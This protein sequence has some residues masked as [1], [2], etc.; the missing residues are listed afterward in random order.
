MQQWHDHGYLHGDVKPENIVV[1]Q[2]RPTS[3]SERGSVG[4]ASGGETSKPCSG[5]SAHPLL[6]Y[7][8][9]V[10][11]A[12]TA[13]VCASAT[14]SDNRAASLPS[15]AP[16]ESAACD[17]SGDSTS[18]CSSDSAASSG[19]LDGSRYGH[20]ALASDSLSKAGPCSA[21]IHDSWAVQQPARY[22]TSR[23]QP[24][25]RRGEASMALDWFALGLTIHWMV[26]PWW[27]LNARVLTRSQAVG[28]YGRR[29]R[30]TS[31]VSSLG[32]Q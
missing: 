11:G 6:A 18:D 17:A 5:E 26:S 8:I 28:L 12:L 2:A 19:D 23:Y 1:A 13:T 20:A 4:S 9:D 21:V 25:D 14:D 24:S 7:F 16:V 31:S 3:S 22:Y 32:C 29:G 10:G 27:Y 15:A 30:A